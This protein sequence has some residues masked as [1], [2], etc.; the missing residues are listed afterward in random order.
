MAVFNLIPL[1]PLDGFKVA[2]GVLPREIASSY[3]RLETYGP[4]ILLLV[5]MVDIFTGAGILGSIISPV[6]N[7]L[8]LVVAGQQ[9]M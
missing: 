5:I 7:F 4:V 2:L 8:G 6:V 1:A 3:A 9:I